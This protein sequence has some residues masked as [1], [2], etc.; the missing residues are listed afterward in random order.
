MRGA[1]NVGPAPELQ[2]VSAGS[3]RGGDVEPIHDLQV[4]EQRSAVRVARALA[5]ARRVAEFDALLGFR[6]DVGFRASAVESIEG[7]RTECRRGRRQGPKREGSG[8][9]DKPEKEQG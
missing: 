8:K 1:F 9:C 5:D 2:D 6:A 3:Q 4:G 7:N